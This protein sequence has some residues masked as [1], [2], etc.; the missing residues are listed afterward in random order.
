MATGIKLTIN[1][2]PI[3]VPDG[4]I[5]AVAIA[6]AGVSTFRKSVLGELRGP[7]CGM[8]ICMECRVEVNGQTHVR[9]CLTVCAE[10]MEVR[11]DG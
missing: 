4:T 8:G 5:L 2:R 10:G 1:G 7:L 9:S 3:E 11:T 6:K